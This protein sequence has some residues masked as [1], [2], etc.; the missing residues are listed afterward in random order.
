MVLEVQQPTASALLDWAASE[1]A[2]SDARP[3]MRVN[4]SYWLPLESGDF[5]V[6]RGRTGMASTRPEDEAVGEC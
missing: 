2:A 5:G 3:E 6:E 4:V 1:G